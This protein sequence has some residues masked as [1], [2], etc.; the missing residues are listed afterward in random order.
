MTSFFP[1]GNLHQ[2]MRFKGKFLS[3][4]LS[5]TSSNSYWGHQPAIRIFFSVPIYLGGKLGGRGIEASAEKGWRVLKLLLDL[6][7]VAYTQ[8]C[9]TVELRKLNQWPFAKLVGI[10]LQY[11]STTIVL[12]IQQKGERKSLDKKIWSRLLWPRLFWLGIQSSQVA[13]GSTAN[14]FTKF[15]IRCLVVDDIRKTLQIQ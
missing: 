12:T 8:T 9:F 15:F 5:G 14:Y 3:L 1:N 13:Q 7:W 11:Y 10:K 2:K 6:N 4:K